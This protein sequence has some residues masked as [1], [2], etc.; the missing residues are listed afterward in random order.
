[1]NNILKVEHL[2]KNYNQKKALDGVSF[3]VKQGE[4]LGL[5]GPNG[6]GKTTI[7]NILATVLSPTSGKITF[8][9]HDLK[10]SFKQI[11]RDIGIVPQDLAIYEEISAEKNV[12]FFASL[13]KLK[14]DECKCQR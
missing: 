13:Y 4:I 7:I 5:L 6:A 1:M 10:K 9:N 12:R 11:K 14:K 2:K 3:E 8:L